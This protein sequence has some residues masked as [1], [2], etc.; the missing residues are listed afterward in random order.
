MSEGVG[1]S[2]GEVLHIRHHN[3]EETFAL[4]ADGTETSLWKSQR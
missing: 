4:D 2:H 3:G 1:D